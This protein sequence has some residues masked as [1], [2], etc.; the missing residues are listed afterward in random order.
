MTVF[1]D[2]ITNLLA[3]KFSSGNEP[4]TG[5]VDKLVALITQLGLGS[6]PAGPASGDLSGNYPNPS[7]AKIQTVGVS[8]AAPVDGNALIYD[9]VTGSWLPTVPAF[10]HP[11]YQ[12][13]RY[14]TM[15]SFGAAGLLGSLNNVL[16]AMPIYIGRD[17]TIQKL[18]AQNTTGTAGSTV[19][20]GIYANANGIP[21]ALIKD[22]GT[23]SVAAAGFQTIA[24]VQAIKAGW[25]WL[26]LADSAGNNYD[27]FATSQWWDWLVGNAGNFATLSNGVTAAGNYSAGL[28]A[29]FPAVVYTTNETPMIA[30]GV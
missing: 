27:A 19:R 10:N 26:A 24:G 23:A 15:P 8:N 5:S 11:G 12:A 29:N 3:N 13:G 7:V 30:F 9:S 6:P 17:I 1:S 4:I 25:Y 2:M 16:Y 22:F 21:G 18:A 14:Y 20:L 28:P